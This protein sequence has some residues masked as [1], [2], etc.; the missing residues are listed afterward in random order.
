M[1]AKN[2]QALAPLRE[3]KGSREFDAHGLRAWSDDYSDIL[4]PFISKL[5]TP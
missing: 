4:G 5:R 3:L 1:F 2:Q